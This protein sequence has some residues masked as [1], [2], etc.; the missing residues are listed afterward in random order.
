MRIESFAPI[1]EKNSRI[2]I[3]GTMPSTESLKK[4]EYYAHPKNHFW[5]IIF[6]TLK[7]DLDF[8][9]PIQGTVLYSDKIELLKENRIALWDTLKFCDRKGNLDK[10]IRNEIKNDF[11]LFFS[12]H[13]EIQKVLFNGKNAHKYFFESFGH[14]VKDKNIE[15][16]L[17]NSTSSSNTNNVFMVLNDWKNKLT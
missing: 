14:L 8:F 9:E 11:D 12:E 16:Y 2:L 7:D 4:G 13:S 5:D 10:D 6:R 15:I 3:I 17:M 1:E